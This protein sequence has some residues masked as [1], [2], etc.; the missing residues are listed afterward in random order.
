[1]NTGVTSPSMLSVR[2]IRS[3]AIPTSVR[4]APSPRA[5]GRSGAAAPAL[6]PAAPVA[7]AADAPVRA[8]RVEAARVRAAPAVVRR[9]LVHVDARRAVVPVARRALA[10]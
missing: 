8:R 9:A 10:A 7:R 3:A 4:D 1:M 6:L 2:A 5:C